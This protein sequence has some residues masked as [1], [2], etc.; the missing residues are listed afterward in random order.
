LQACVV[1]NHFLPRSTKI[2][3]FPFTRE[4]ISFGPT[5]L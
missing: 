5:R 2:A 3:L 4:F 1:V